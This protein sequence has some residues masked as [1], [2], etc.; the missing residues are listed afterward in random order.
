MAKAADYNAQVAFGEDVIT[1]IIYA[2]KGTGLAKLQSVVVGTMWNL[3]KNL[4]EEAGIEY[5]D[6]T[7]VVVAGNT[8][9]M[10][11]LLGLNPKYIREEPYIPS[12][13]FFPW[14]K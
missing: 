5:C 14:I 7:D 4:V 13:T 10:H 12:A 1:R 2:T 8:T 9:M 6:V 11:L 3:I